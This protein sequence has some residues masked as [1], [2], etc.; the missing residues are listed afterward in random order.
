MALTAKQKAF[1]EEYVANGYKPMDAYRVIFPD[2]TDATVKSNT[3]VM[4]KR[5]EVKEY[6]QQI[7]KERFEA[8]N[9]SAERIAEKLAE[10]AFS[11]KNDEDYTATSQLKA[12]DL[13]QKQMGLQNQKVELNGKQDIVINIGGTDDEGSCN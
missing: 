10:I 12:L 9:I 11:A 2:A 4:L 8:L 13:L 5:P 6:I 3:Y 1:A 7:Q